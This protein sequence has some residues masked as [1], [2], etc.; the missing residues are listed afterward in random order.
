MKSP[1]IEIVDIPVDRIEAD[2]ENVNELSDEGYKALRDEIAARG[3]V[4]PCLVR[5]VPPSSKN[6]AIEYR[7]VDGE[8]RWLALTEL[9][10]ETC[11]CVVQPMD[12]T[13]AQVRSMLMNGL[14]GSFV[15]VKLAHLLA[16]LQERIPAEELQ[17][18]L[19]MDKADFDGLLDVAGFLE[20]D[21]PKEPTPRP[22]KQPGV[23]VAVVANQG[24][25]EE[26]EKLLAGLTNGDPERNAAVVA[27]KAREALAS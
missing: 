1:Q 17:S 15:P 25:A 20:P 11:P 27:R 24:Q 14:R 16:D 10:A 22:E 5:P 13:E 26:I 4:Q 6:P 2:P 12:A 8:H 19:A 18:R 3:F 21:E 23:E 9:G 7:M